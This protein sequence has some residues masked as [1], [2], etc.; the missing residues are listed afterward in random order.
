MLLGGHLYAQEELLDQLE[1]DATQTTAYPSFKA[2][3]MVNLQST[4]M[5]SRNDFYF[6]ISHRFGSL[7]DGADTFFGLDNA[8]TKIGFIYGIREWVSVG[9]SRHTLNK[10]YEGTLKYRLIEQNEHAPVT[11]V[12]Y[13]TVQVNSQLDSDVYPNLSFENRLTY[14]SQALVSRSISTALTLEVIVSYI[15]KNTYNAE[16]EHQDQFSIGGGG[17]IKLSK[18]LSINAEYMYSD[19]PSFYNNPLSVGLDIETGG[20]VFQLLFTNSQGMTE[21]SYLTNASGDWGRGEIYFG[22]NLYR[23]F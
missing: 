18:R 6:L 9:I 3:Q 12:G 13:H 16:I 1:M 22:F 23:V 11:L 14:A 19:M 2:L 7:K 17:R 5:P 4:K 10:A 8:T 15:Y 21:S 20:H